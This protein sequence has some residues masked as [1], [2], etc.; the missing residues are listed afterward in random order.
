ML[1]RDI[2]SQISMLMC[3]TAELGLTRLWNEDL[4]IRDNALF[5]RRSRERPVGIR[6]RGRWER[7]ESQDPPY[8]C[9][10]ERREGGI[11]SYGVLRS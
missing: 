4:Q 9:Q 6:V 1:D 10:R 2:L 8:L 11:E 3:R 7:C 5:A